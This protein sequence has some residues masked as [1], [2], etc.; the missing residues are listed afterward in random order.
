MTALLVLGLLAI[1]YCLLTDEGYLTHYRWPDGLG[2]AAQLVNG[3]QTWGVRI[4]YE[5]HPAPWV[6]RCWRYEAPATWLGWPRALRVRAW[7]VTI[8]FYLGAPKR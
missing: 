2:W 4:Q 5:A 1:A 3:K 7:K 8:F 6:G